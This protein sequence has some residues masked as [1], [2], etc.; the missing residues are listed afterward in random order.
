MNKYWINANEV[1][2]EMFRGASEEIL[3]ETGV[4]GFF[5]TMLWINNKIPLLNYHANRL[6]HSAKIQNIKSNIAALFR[7][8]IS[9]MPDF[10][11]GLAKYQVF[12]SMSSNRVDRFLS[13]EN[14]RSYPASNWTIGIA[15]FLPEE[16]LVLDAMSGGIKS[17][18]R[19]AYEQLQS[20]YLSDQYAEILVK[21][22]NDF[23]V[24]GT[25]TNIF[26][27]KANQI[28]TPDLQGG[29]VAGVMRAY[30]IQQM[31]SCGITVQI[32]PVTIDTMNSCDT[33]FL[34]NALIGLW[35]VHTLVDAGQNSH[36]KNTKHPLI[37][38]IRTLLPREFKHG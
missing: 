8:D 26:L 25:K 3:H 30:L 17:T 15:T 13:V 18:E 5:E 34:S 31:K 33:M 38:K 6:K 24:E 11:H 16:S 27:I 12:H 29:G 36:S 2:V 1:S 22:D 35:P 14:P 37:A 4:S 32:E 19:S 7:S 28:I 10:E 21:D 20:K 9:L 23:V